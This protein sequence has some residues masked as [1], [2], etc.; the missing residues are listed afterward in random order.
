MA[1]RARPKRFQPP[2]PAR[3]TGYRARPAPPLGYSPYHPP[4]SL[5]RHASW[6]CAL[7]IAFVSWYPLSGWRDL[8]LSPLAFIFAPLPTYRTL[9]DLAANVV[10]YLPLGLCLVLALSPRWRGGVACLIATFM[11][12]AWSGLMEIGQVYLPAR[13]PS[14]L[15]TLLNTLGTLL[16]AAFGVSRFNQLLG[17]AALARWRARWLQPE[18]HFALILLGLWLLSQWRPQ[19]YLFA[20]GDW[21]QYLLPWLQSWWPEPLPW[22]NWSWWLKF[23]PDSQL[24]SGSAQSVSRALSSE[25]FV[26]IETLLVT[27]NLLVPGCLLLAS[28]HTTAP[29]R[30][31]LLASGAAVL[32][33][34]ALVH[35]I[36]LG[37]SATWSWLTPGA[38]AGMALAGLLLLSTINLQLS[39]RHLLQLALLALFGSF[40]LVNLAPENLYAEAQLE[41]W[42]PGP[43]FNWHGLVLWL[44]AGWPVLT[45]LYLI[46]HLDR[47]SATNR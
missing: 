42:S 40:F 24:A 18:A 28:L 26:A 16:G 6:V 7:L 1:R 32:L 13:V 15:D 19:P 35:R 41:S 11:G 8:G 3:A 34:K 43:W 14:N 20:V 45:L 12:F 44:D 30:R 22:L 47:P 36:L 17:L 46:K 5:A 4:T 29:Q 25:A 39:R 27:A 23:F 2:S 33:S 10:A 37:V 21:A 31:L 38:W 9:F